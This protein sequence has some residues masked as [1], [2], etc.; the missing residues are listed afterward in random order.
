MSWEEC[1]ETRQRC[2]EEYDRIMQDPTAS[3]Q[4][5]L[6]A[7]EDMVLL[8]MLTILPPDRVGVIRKLCNV[9]LRKV[10]GRWCIDLTQERN[11]HKTA[12]FY[13]GMLALGTYTL[14][15]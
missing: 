4:D 5:K 12:R 15:A 13:G 10:D 6:K 9:T 1:Q 8:C 2:K 11:V 7:S 14:L 3:R